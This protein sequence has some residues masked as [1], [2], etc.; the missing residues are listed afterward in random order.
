MNN[1]TE[2]YA[3]QI[4]EKVMNVIPYNI[5]M[6]NNEGIIISSGDENRIGYLHEG[7]LKAILNNKIVTIYKEKGGSRPGVNMPIVFQNSVIG[8]IG[9][10]GSPNKVMPF[11][12]LVKITA[13]LLLEQ[14]Y[15]F[16]QKR[17][18]EKIKE[19]FL[20]QWAYVSEYDDTFLE[21]ADLLKI[22]LNLERIAVIISFKDKIINVDIIK[23]YLC[24]TEYVLRFNQEDILIFMKWDRDFLNRINNIKSAFININKIAIGSKNKFFA[25]SVKEA[26]K[27]ISI[28]KKLDIPYDICKYEDVKFIDILS[29]QKD[30][31]K[32]LDIIEKLKKDGKGLELI[33]T[34]KMYIFFNGEASVVAKKMYIHRNS[35]NYRL[36]KIKDITG[37]NPKK[38]IDLLELY[39]AYVVYKLKI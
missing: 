3:K 9:I 36:K 30:N 12:S 7:A 22:D 20:Y 11:A 32:L 27:V 24:T 10:S 23:A 16:N 15:V 19:E 33:E 2:V 29:K 18:K 35:L 14:E 1:L 4:V 21:R 37:K 6:M 38:T 8:V 25:K 17:V 34:L 39:A 13:E 5:N 28:M 26:R 31:K